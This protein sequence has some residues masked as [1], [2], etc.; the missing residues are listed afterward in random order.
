[1][2]DKG[3]GAIL[4]GPLA[5]KRRNEMSTSENLE[6]A[7]AGESQANRKYLAFAKKAEDDGFTQVARLFRAA[8]GS[9]TPNDC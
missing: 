1:M 7:F 5:N 2:W 9:N 4:R 3:Q 6:A 8:H